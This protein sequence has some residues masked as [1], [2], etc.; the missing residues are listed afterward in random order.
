MTSDC[1]PHQVDL[2]PA[3]DISVPNWA[4]AVLAALEEMEGEDEESD[5]A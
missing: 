4:A 3:A 1:L 2:D 5:V